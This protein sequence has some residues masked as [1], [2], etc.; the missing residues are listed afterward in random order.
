MFRSGLNIISKMTDFFYLKLNKYF[1][2]DSAGV[3]TENRRLLIFAVLVL[4]TIGGLKLAITVL[5]S[6]KTERA[7]EIKLNIDGK[8][9]SVSCFVDS[10]NLA[11]DPL[12]QTPVVFLTRKTFLR[13]FGTA[14]LPCE[15]Y[16][17]QIRLIPIKQ[18]GISHIYYGLKCEDV[19]LVC[20][21][22]KE[23]E[24]LVLV[25]GDEESYG[26]YDGLAPS[27]IATR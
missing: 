14:S 17:S 5:S 20:K 19:E 10:G 21:N 24:S 18:R 4:L 22:S 11:C 13:V 15:K 7:V 1:E 26:G 9:R 8:V 27:I 12:D 3:A 6:A 16:K 23:R 25:L 2:L